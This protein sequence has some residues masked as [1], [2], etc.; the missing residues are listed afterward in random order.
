MY[1]DHNFQETCVKSQN[2]P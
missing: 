1:F 2:R